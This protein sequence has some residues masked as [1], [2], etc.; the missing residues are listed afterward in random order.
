MVSRFNFIHFLGIFVYSVSQSKQD[1][2][3]TSTTTSKFS[4]SLRLNLK[5]VSVSDTPTHLRRR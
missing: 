5:S 4:N 1:V 3:L 2:F